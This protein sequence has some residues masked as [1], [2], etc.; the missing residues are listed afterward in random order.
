MAYAI[1][2]VQKLKTMGDI[3][4]SI[5]HNYRTRYTPN[6]DPSKTVNNEHDL[7][8]AAE[9]LEAIK[10]RI[11]EKHRKDAVLCVEHLITASPEWAGWGDPEREK[12]FFDKSRK[13][14]I[15]K[16]GSQNVIATSIHRDETTPHLVAYIVP[17]DA[18][19]GRLNAKKYIGGTRHVLSQMQTDFAKC[20]QS[21][22][23]E[24]GLEGSKAEHTT[25]QKYY[26]ELVHQENTA[27][28]FERPE[29]PRKSMFTESAYE[30]GN[31]VMNLVYEHV[32]HDIKRV[33]KENTE[34]KK[35][36]HDLEQEV[37]RLRYF[38]RK[39]KPYSDYC[40]LF[41][42]QA[43]DLDRKFREATKNELERREKVKLEREQ[44]KIRKE[45]E[46]KAEQERIAQQRQ[47]PKV[48]KTYSYDDEPPKKKNNDFE[49]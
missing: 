40:R 6:A 26:S 46:H 9:A 5:S 13:W 23:L 8:T 32:D 12:T 10:G 11:P 18:N 21:L 48:R 34:L 44:D 43:I 22:G 1:L 7:Q 27:P 42:D 24:R 49:M 38:E 25:I 36:V 39:N 33:Q 30:Y 17:L 41:P 37:G 35:Q 20:V 2:R 16:Y 47:Q 15:D 19:T 31:R 3:G 29:L 4:G 45:Q 28:V 14:L